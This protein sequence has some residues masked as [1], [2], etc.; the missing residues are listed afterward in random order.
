MKEGGREAPGWMYWQFDV[1]M[2][3]LLRKLPNCAHVMVKH[4][5]LI[6]IPQH[7]CAASGT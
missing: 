7:F 4:Y 1:S 2:L 6:E 3:F 5:S